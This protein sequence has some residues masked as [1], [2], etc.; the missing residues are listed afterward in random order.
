[1]NPLNELRNLLNPQHAE[2]I[3]TIQSADHPQYKVLLVDG[4][5]L[6][7]CTSNVKYNTGQR[8]FIQNQEIKRPAPLGDV[9]TIDI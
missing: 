8:V 4:S 7:L 3:G 2:Y 6:V 9:I 1:M 5:G